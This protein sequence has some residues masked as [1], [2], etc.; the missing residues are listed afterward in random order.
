MVAAVVSAIFYIFILNVQ[1]MKSLFLALCLLLLAGL[2]DAQVTV[3]LPCSKDAAIGYHDGAGTAGNNYGS[4]I[5]NA[6]FMI[7]SAA[8]PS[9]SNGNRALIG[10]NLSTIPAGATILSAN[11][12]LYAIGPFGSVQGH[13][14][15]NSSYLRRITQSWGEYTA[16]WNNQ[17]TAT[18]QNQ[19]ILP[20]SASATQNYLNI[21]VLAMVQDMI[22]NPA[23]GYGFLLGLVNE[24]NTN[25]LCFASRDHSNQALH[26]TLEVVYETC[27]NQNL[28]L[29]PSPAA[30]VCA[31][32]TFAMMSTG[33]NGSIS[34]YASAS[35][36]T[37]IG[38]NVFYSPPGVNTFTPG[39]YTYY[40]G[41]PGCLSSPRAAVSVTVQPLP[42]VSASADR[43]VICAGEPVT[44][45]AGGALTY[46]WSNGPVAFSQS[47]S[48]V[49]GPG[50]T[51][52]YY[53]SGMLGGCTGTAQVQV[54]VD[55]CTFTDE[56]VIQRAGL[57]IYPNP[58]VH[59]FA[60]RSGGA[61]LFDQLRI[62]DV[63]GR[64]VKTY[65]WPV[66]RNSCEIR[67][68]G[69]APGIYFCSILNGSQTLATKKIIISD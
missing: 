69:L 21:N 3:L 61:V 54:V 62:C 50:T 20:A 60:I 52:S 68:A 8:A 38:T 55:K 57:D 59:V 39:I 27:S 18:T 45:S 29:Y 15:A 17:P 65:T 53:L 63:Q 19:V 4:A 25:G 9:G 1:P 6:A 31:G 28:G 48:Q 24:V 10:F 42:A 13:F 35:S 51:T 37:V 32:Q 46:T 33:S 67:D 26:P 40:A 43:S 2:L 44:L 14:G 22:S 41:V 66:G 7:P 58:S 49:V 30:T 34:W 64:P 12:N 36:Q 56:T 16:T 5:Q 11:L 47:P 23:P